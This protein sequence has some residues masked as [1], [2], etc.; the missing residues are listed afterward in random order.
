MQKREELLYKD[1][2][3]RA[4]IIASYRKKVKECKAQAE[5]VDIR[6]RDTR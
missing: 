5:K 1:S 2:K 4:R 6:V 3:E